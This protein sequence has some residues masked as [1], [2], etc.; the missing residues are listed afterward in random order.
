MKLE[1]QK[2][3]ISI[4]EQTLRELMDA[5]EKAKASITFT[6][7]PMPDCDMDEKTRYEMK[8]QRGEIT[9]SSPYDPL[10]FKVSLETKPHTQES[11]GYK[12]GN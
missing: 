8:R 5:I 3:I 11:L 1:I 9:I 10:S 6:D 7:E 4:T 2:G 12:N